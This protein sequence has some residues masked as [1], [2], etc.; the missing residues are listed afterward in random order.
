M[1]LDTVAGRDGPAPLD[2]LLTAHWATVATFVPTD[3]DA[4]IRHHAWQAMGTVDEVAA[5]CELVDRVA[6][7]DVRAVSARVYDG[8][9]GPLSGHD[10]EWFS[11][12]AGAVFRAAMLGAEDLVLRIAE[13]DRRRSSRAKRRSSWRRSAS[14]GRCSPCRRSSRTTWA[15]SRVVA[16]WSKLELLTPLRDRWLRLGHADAAVPRPAFVNAGIL[17]KALMAHENHRFLPL[18]KARGLR[19]SRSLLLPIGPWLDAWGETIATSELLEDTDRAEVLAALLEVHGRDANQEGCLRAISGL[20]R[21]LRGGIEKLVPDLPARMRKDAVRGKV[22]DVLDI[23]A[24]RFAARMDKKVE[25]LSK[26][27]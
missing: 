12:R 13:S 24:D 26:T 1:P 2:A 6:K 17:N 4:R 20:H 21:A 14:R 25:T 22:R 9:Q 27:R 3:V 16:D 19:V 7:N 8:P 10:G 5:A 15:I 23:D 18:R 11:V